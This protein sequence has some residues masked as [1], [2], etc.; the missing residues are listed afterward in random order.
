M[1][2]C[3]G[4]QSI[5]IQKTGSRKRTRLGQ[6]SVSFVYTC[7]PDQSM[8][9]EPKTPASWP[10]PSCKQPKTL[11]FR[12]TEDVVFKTL[13]SVYRDMFEAGDSP[14]SWFTNSSECE[15]TLST[16]SDESGVGEEEIETVLRGF[17]SERFF[18]E[19]GDTKSI[20]ATEEE[21]EEV[22][23]EEAAEEEVGK[24]GPA[25]PYEESVVLAMESSDPY[26]DFRTSMEEMVAALGL[27]DW[28]CLEELLLWYLKVNGKKNHG[29]IVGA[30]VDLLVS[31][32]S[33]TFDESE[34]DH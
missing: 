20:V 26:V 14:A 29:F 5:R 31:L 12:A 22:A 23:E 30:F 32:V 21:E 13:N 19:P 24:V 8:A 2:A 7:H 34:D 9:K 1:E 18:F 10:W 33:S 25:A 11:S 28:D 15:S 27:N 6:S 4:L 3:A 17:Q 16:A